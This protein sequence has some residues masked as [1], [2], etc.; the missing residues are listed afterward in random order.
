MNFFSGSALRVTS[1]AFHIFTYEKN[2][3]D[4]HRNSNVFTTTKNT[5]S[6]SLEE[7]VTEI[8]YYC[9]V[10]CTSQCINNNN[11]NTLLKL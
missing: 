5:S 8:Y 2:N 9:R 3:R 11:N 6:V 10:K 7:S 1:P 4:T